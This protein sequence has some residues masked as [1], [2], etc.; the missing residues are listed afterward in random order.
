MRRTAERLPGRR[1]RARRGRSRRRDLLRFSYSHLTQAQNRT[2]WIRYTAH[3]AQL[4]AAQSRQGYR[5]AL[6]PGP[7]RFGGDRADRPTCQHERQVGASS[8]PSGDAGDAEQDWKLSQA[9]P[10]ARLR[11]EMLATIVVGKLQSCHECDSCA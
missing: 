5:T 9:T 6:L 10:L 4:Q 8:K 11:R 3:P 7:G 1:R 2:F